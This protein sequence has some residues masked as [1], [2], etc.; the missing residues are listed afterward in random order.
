MRI[1]QV[2]GTIDPK[3]GGPTDSVRAL[4]RYLPEGYESEIVSLDDPSEAFL[5]DLPCVVH[6]LGKPVGGLKA[7]LGYNGRLAGWLA[8]NRDRFDGVMVNGLWQYCGYATWRA[9]R[10]RKP[11]VVFSHGML[12]PYFKRTFRLKHMKKWVY[13]LLAEYW[14]L[15]GAYRVL[16]TTTEEAALAEESFWLHRWQGMVIPFGANRPPGDGEALR[17]VYFGAYP[18]MRGRRFL[19]FLG[20]IHRKKGCDMLI[21]AF[22]RSAADDA[23]LHLLMAGPDQ[24]GWSASLQKMVAE[25]GLT[26][27][28]HWPGMLNGDVKWGAIFAS[29][30]FV[31]P[32]HQENFGIAVAEAMACGKSVL[33]ADKVN[34]AA[35]I[36]ARGAGLMETDTQE[37]TDSLLRRWITMPAAGREQMEARASAMFASDFDMQTNAETI[38]RVFEGAGSFA[39]G[40]RGGSQDTH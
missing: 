40:S 17:E 34:I 39:Q 15:R 9:M 16:F 31:L 19:L 26:A 14:V 36:A 10:G 13:W 5:G 12:D 18:E 23:G 7:G 1:L 38:N 21:R 4:V 25:A 30:A 6:A 2:I 37:G 33:L 11:Y 3:A 20:R 35:G 32:S 29:E 8:E 27:R 24:Q 28:V 22:I